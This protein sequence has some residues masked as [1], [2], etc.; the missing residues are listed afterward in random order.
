MARE[1]DEEGNLWVQ[2]VSS[3]PATRVDVLN[4]QV[5]IFILIGCM[6]IFDL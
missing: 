6:L 2:K 5:K 4:L 1:W 3:T